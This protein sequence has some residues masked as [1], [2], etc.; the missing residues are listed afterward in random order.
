MLL[1]SQG[2]G[3]SFRLDW[4]KGLGNILRALLS[5]YLLILSWLG[6]PLQ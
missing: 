4:G 6:F 3:T 2:N 1:G 5:L